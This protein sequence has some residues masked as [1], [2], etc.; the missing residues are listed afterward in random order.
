MA[1]FSDVKRPE[2]LYSA[3]FGVSSLSTFISWRWVRRCASSI[4]SRLENP[5]IIDPIEAPMAFPLK[6]ETGFDRL[7]NFGGPGNSSVCRKFSAA[8]LLAWSAGCSINQ[9]RCWWCPGGG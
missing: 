7:G 1:V 9:W 5:A 3:K 2:S 6:E 8:D 4:A